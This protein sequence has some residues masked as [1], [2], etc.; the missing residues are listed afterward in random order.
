MISRGWIDEHQAQMP[1]FRGIS[2][3]QLRKIASF[4]SEVSGRRG[5]V[6]THE[7]RPGSEF[8]MVYEGT[9]EVLAGGRLVATRGT[10]DY[11]GEIALLGARFRT[12]TAVAT[13][14]V[15]V[16]VLSRRE[17]SSLLA[18]VPELTDQLRAGIDDRLGELRTP[19]TDSATRTPVGGVRVG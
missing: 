14:P 4:G 15:V 8:F 9:V 16:K 18:E 5:M 7:G 2:K 1:L 6:L 19:S 17:F 10:G 12:A 13:T 3:H 11:L